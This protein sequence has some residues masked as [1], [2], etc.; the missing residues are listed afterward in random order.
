M[1]KEIKSGKDC[2][3]SFRI[4]TKECN[5]H[6]RMGIYK[7]ILSSQA[8]Y[9][10][11]SKVLADI[12]YNLASDYKEMAINAFNTALDQISLLAPGSEVPNTYYEARKTFMNRFYLACSN[13]HD[14]DLQYQRA[15]SISMNEVFDEYSE[16][17]RVHIEELND[18]KQVLLSNNDKKTD[19]KTSHRFF[20]I[21]DTPSN[22]SLINSTNE[23]G[24]TPK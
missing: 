12:Y 21:S 7:N 23:L 24:F 19:N 20:G 10:L 15:K 13:F 2:V 9:E 17:T 8:K 18:Y 4:A 3:K 14:A 22:T 16:V 1:T 6:S 11:E 5:I